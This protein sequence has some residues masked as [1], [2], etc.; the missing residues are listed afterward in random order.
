MTTAK[1]ILT[2]AIALV[3]SL[4]C[5]AAFA[6]SAK[7]Q[8]PTKNY[9]VLIDNAEVR[10]MRAHFTPHEKTALHSLRD[11]VVV[12]LNAYSV[13]A[14]APNGKVELRKRRA[15]DA[16]WLPAGESVL[17]AGRRPINAV[18]V[19]IKNSHPATKSQ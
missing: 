12:P 16:V 18:V 8:P 1:P 5:T 17:E 9:T 4:V 10:V 3:L 15:G 7:E 11:S 2:G 13:K 6:Q 19:E 14:T